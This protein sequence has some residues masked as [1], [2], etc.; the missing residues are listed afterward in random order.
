MADEH[1]R[2]LSKS[3]Y[4]DYFREDIKI[5][6]I[7]SP[8]YNITLFGIEKLHPFDSTKYAKVHDRLIELGTIP[9][10]GFAE[11]T[12][13]SEE[14]LKIVHTE[15]YLNSLKWSLVLTRI[16]EIPILSVFPQFVIQRKVL[17]PMLYQ[18][19]G[20]VIAGQLALIH[21]WAINLGGGFHHASG[22]DGG[23]FCVYADLTLSIKLLRIETNVTRAMIVDLDAHQGNGHERDFMNDQNVF[24]YDMFNSYIYPHDTY[25]MRRISKAVKVSPGTTEDMYLASLRDTLPECLDNFQPEIIYYNAGTD[26]LKGD[27]LGNMTLTA[28]GIR[29]RDEI[30]FQEALRRKIPIVMVLS[31]G[32]ARGTAQ[33]IGDSIHNLVTKFDLLRRCEKK[34]NFIPRSQPLF[35]NEESSASEELHSSLDDEQVIELEHENQNNNNII[36]INQYED[37]T[38]VKLKEK[39]SSRRQSVEKKRNNNNNMNRSHDSVPHEED[40]N[41]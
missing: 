2:L 17:E 7:Y 20:T 29:E 36:V 39:S 28:E 40:E 9:R 13:P 11:P 31:G 19:G 30:V 27:P 4:R 24:I 15:R 26:C 12:K 5:P 38:K 32:Y 16:L 3:G 37:N 22:D 34:S 6:I 33:V 41:V 21:G 18:T 10:N 14:I 25:A 23:G 35:M 8:K 1:Q